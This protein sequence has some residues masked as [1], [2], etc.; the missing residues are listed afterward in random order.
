MLSLSLSLSLSLLSFFFTLA[1]TYVEPFARWEVNRDTTIICL[2]IHAQ[3]KTKKRN[4]EKKKVKV[5]N[6]ANICG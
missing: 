5:E 1:K 6:E 3:N 2:H 4:I